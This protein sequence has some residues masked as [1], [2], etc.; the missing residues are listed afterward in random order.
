MA[1]W[2]SWRRPCP[3]GCRRW[4]RRLSGPPQLSFNTCLEQS[5]LL[6]GKTDVSN[7]LLVP[8]SHVVC[9]HAFFTLN[10]AS[11]NH[12]LAVT[13]SRPISRREHI[14]HMFNISFD[15]WSFSRAMSKI[16]EFEDVFKLFLAVGRDGNKSC[17]RETSRSLVLS[18]IFDAESK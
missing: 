14:V 2:R 10:T 1:T 4:P 8:R 6:W 17:S 13:C 3:G 9:R 12:R 11:S 18:V 5:G 16:V 15:C 7:N